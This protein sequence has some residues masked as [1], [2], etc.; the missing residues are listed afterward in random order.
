[1]TSS[2]SVA[3][4]TSRAFSVN[5]ELRARVAANL[6]LLRQRVATAS[7]WPDRVRVVAVTKTLDVT[8]VEVAL[9]LGLDTLGENYVD[10]LCEKRRATSTTAQW[11]FLGA[12]QSNKIARAL[13]C[14]DVLCGVSRAKEVRTIARL[15][16]GAVID[17]QVDFTGAAQRNGAPRDEVGSLVALAR[18]LGLE[19]RGLM[20]VAPQDPHA[21]EAAFVATSALA[22]QLELSERSMGMSD[23]LEAACRAGSTEIRV[24][25]A[26]FGPR[27]P[28]GRLA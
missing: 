20:T 11:H 6:A 18:E 17:V 8:Y 3:M 23:D 4:T 27:V 10:E 12:L 13:E 9:A 15:R 2:I 1:M 19:V 24:G 7:P 21:G 5:D 28:V 16:P 22:D 14:A 26:L 25:R